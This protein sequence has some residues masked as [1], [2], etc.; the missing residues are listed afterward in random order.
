MAAQMSHHFFHSIVPIWFY[1]LTILYQ[2][3]LVVYLF[4]FL[5]ETAALPIAVAFLQGSFQ[6]SI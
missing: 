6:Y 3:F 1:L 4:A 5:I 2:S